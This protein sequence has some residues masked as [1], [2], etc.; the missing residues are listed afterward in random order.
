MTATERAIA[1]LWYKLVY[2]LKIK[3]LDD[4]PEQYRDLLEDYRREIEG[5]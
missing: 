4:V 5:D 2:K 1:K 3:S